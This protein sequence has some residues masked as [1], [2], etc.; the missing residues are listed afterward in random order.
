MFLFNAILSL[1]IGVPAVAGWIRY[2]K[3]RPVFYPFIWWLS[4][5]FIAE[6]L[7]IWSSYRFLNNNT[8]NNVYI[9]GAPIL[10]VHFLRRWNHRFIPLT[11]CILVTI[12]SLG[13]FAG[14]WIYYGTLARFFSP[15]VITNSTIVVLASVRF[16]SKHLSTSICY[17]QRDAPSLIC[18]GI[19]VL[20]IYTIFTECFLIWAQSSNAIYAFCIPVIYSIINVIVNAVFLIA[21]LCIPLKIQFFLRR[22]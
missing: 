16:F 18:L 11:V 19:I 10:I 3:I 15:L 7:S 9:M 5:G 12:I 4:A 6:V 14:L 8:V 2:P 13:V 1:L 21:V 22:Y 20:H 17:I